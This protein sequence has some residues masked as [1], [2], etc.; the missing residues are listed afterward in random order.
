M[1][2][3]APIVAAFLTHTPALLAG[4]CTRLLLHHL[5]RRSGSALPGLVVDT[6]APKLVGHALGGFP[7]GLVVVSGSS[8][9]STTTMMLVA[10]LR[11]HGLT[12]FT[13]ESTANLRRGITSAV[14]E[15]ATLLGRID[16]DI[17]VVEID[18]GAAADMAAELE[19]RVVVLT[20]VMSDQLD[21]FGSTQRVVGLLAR[22]AERATHRVVANLDDGLLVDLATTLVTPVSWFGSSSALRRSMRNGLGYARESTTGGSSAHTVLTGA[23]LHRAQIDSNGRH[24]EIVLP[25]RGTHFAMDAAA[26]IEAAV[27]VLGERFDTSTTEGAFA[28]LRPVF[29]RGEVVQINGE[30]VEL[31]LVQ[32]RSSFQLNLDDLEPR[33]E[34][35]LLAVGSDVRDPSWL[36]SVQT[37]SLGRVDMVTGSKAYDLALRLAYAG[38]HTDAVEPELAEALTRFLTLPRPTTGRKT[39]VF[40]ADPMRR[41]RRQLGLDGNLVVAPAEPVAA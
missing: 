38:V 17:A 37:E 15:A 22:I 7:E 2:R 9:K 6:V 12:V 14:V 28:D 20:N 21:R 5:L 18:E 4:R 13:N 16:A 30:E 32:N 27:A 1:T 24:L 3:P 26:A 36:W 10:I 19:P 40:S 25:A 35:L 31:V 29:G 41:I 23:T 11:A 33:P 39:L 34:Q 8:G